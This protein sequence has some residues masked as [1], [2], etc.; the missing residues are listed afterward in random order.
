[1]FLE[2]EKNCQVMFLAHYLIAHERGRDAKHLE[3]DLLSSSFVE[4]FFLQSC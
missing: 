3:Q 4:F 1:M 2:E